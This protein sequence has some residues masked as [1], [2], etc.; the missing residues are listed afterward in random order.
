MLN[1]LHLHKILTGLQ[2]RSHNGFTCETQLLVTMHDLIIYKGSKLQTYIIL[3]DL[4]N[5]FNTVSHDNLLHKLR[6]YGITADI[7]DLI[8]IFLKHRD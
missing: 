4:S 2:H 8:S 1:H 7:L 3:L 6:H 5:V